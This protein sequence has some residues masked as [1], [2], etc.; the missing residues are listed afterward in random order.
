MPSRKTDFERNDR[1]ERADLDSY[2]QPMTEKAN[3]LAELVIGMRYVQRDVKDIKEGLERNYVTQEAFEPIKRIV[4]GL[5]A[6]ILTAVVVALLA[7]II[8]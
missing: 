8:Q 2:E 7:L 3:T 5:V 6:L 4:Y 1:D